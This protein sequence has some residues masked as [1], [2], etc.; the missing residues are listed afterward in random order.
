MEDFRFQLECGLY[1]SNSSDSLREDKGSNQYYKGLTGNRV[2]WIIG[3]EI[4]GS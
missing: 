4:G 2:N 3:R 1:L